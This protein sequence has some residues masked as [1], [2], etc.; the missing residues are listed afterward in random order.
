MVADNCRLSYQL[1]TLVILM[2]RSAKLKRKCFKSGN[3]ANNLS[4]AVIKTDMQ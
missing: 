4:L 2:N 3:A 1:Y